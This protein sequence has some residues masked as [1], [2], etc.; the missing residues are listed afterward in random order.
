MK[1]TIR[2]FDPFAPGSFKQIM[3]MTRAVSSN[4]PEM[5]LQVVKTILET[6]C[7][8]EDCTAEEVLNSLSLADAM[9]LIEQY[10]EGARNFPSLTKQMSS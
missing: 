4:D 9:K 5:V 6:N 7:D 8:F 2:P 3:L 10:T 1:Y